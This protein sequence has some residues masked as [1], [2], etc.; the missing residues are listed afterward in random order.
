MQE[1]HGKDIIEITQK[2]LGLIMAWRRGSDIN[3][4]KK[5]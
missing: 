2:Q 4:A 3:I 5:N 1:Y